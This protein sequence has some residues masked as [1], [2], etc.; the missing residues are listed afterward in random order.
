[1]AVA[2]IAAG[3]VAVEADGDRAGFDGDEEPAA[4]RF[5]RGEAGRGGEAVDPAG[6]AHAENR[7]AADVG[8]QAD[9]RAVAGVEAGGGDAGGRHRDHAVDVRWLQARLLDRR[10]G[11][12]TKQRVACIQI[13]PVAFLPTMRAFIPDRSAR[14]C[15]AGQCRHCRTRP[16]A[17]RTAPCGRR[18]I[19]EPWLSRRLVQRCSGGRAV[20]SERRP[21]LSIASLS[22]APLPSGEIG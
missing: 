14:R 3:I 13:E 6:A 8:A 12:L 16:P 4:A 5:R 9:R 19:R 7:H 10:R 11:R 17:G 18:T 21:T 22:F 2:T 20:A 1:M 15:A